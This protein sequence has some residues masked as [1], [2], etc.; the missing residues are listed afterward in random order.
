MTFE[1]PGQAGGYQRALQGQAGWII[2]LAVDDQPLQRLGDRYPVMLVV[3]A[4]DRRVIADHAALGG[5][6]PQ[7]VHV[8]AVVPGGQLLRKSA[9]RLAGEPH[10]RPVAT[11]AAQNQR[12]IVAGEVAEGERATADAILLNGAGHADLPLAK[13]L[14]DACYRADFDPSSSAPASHAS[15]AR[16]ACTKSASFVASLIPGAAS[17][18][19][20]TSTAHGRSLRT[21]SPTLPAFRPPAR[22]SGCP[23]TAGS[24]DQSKTLPPP[25]ASPG[26]CPSS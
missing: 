25:P 8:G 20:A 9:V 13:H 10:Q 24:N 21:A 4:F 2:L 7:D 3:E 22:I 18:P 1:K 26:A 12:S 23:G 17:T 5:R 19:L 11:Q 6:Q 14:H 15:A 16:T